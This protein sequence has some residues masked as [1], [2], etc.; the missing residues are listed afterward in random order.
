MGEHAAFFGAD[1]TLVGITTEPAPGCDR[2]M[3][4]VFLNAGVIHRVGPSR[5]YV[6][7]ARELASIGCTAVRFD[8]SGIGDSAARRDHLP[9]EKCAVSEAR[10][11]MDALHQNR[12]LDRFIL[13]GLCSGAVTAFETA[14]VDDRVRGVVLINPQGFDQS[15]EWNIYVHSRDDAR[16]YWTRSLFSAP[17]WKNALLGRIDYRRLGRVLR[18]QASERIVGRREVSSIATRVASDLDALTRRGVRIL[19]LCSEGD[20]GIEYLNMIFGRDIRR[21]KSATGLHLEILPGADHS[22]TLHEGQHRVIGAV[23]DWF[24]KVFI[25]ASLSFDRR[26]S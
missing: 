26:V 14:V 7:I 20:I 19:L 3:A 6:R 11:V 5:L 18:Q 25:G 17:S 12:G 15:A 1:Q 13:V 22:L 9:F 8:H 24:A 21:A 23:C 16:R 10:E 2:R 4:V